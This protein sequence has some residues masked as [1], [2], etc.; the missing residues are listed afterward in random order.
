[1]ATF[2]LLGNFCFI[3]IDASS[4]GLNFV[5]E[6]QLF[7]GTVFILEIYNISRIG[8]AVR[9]WKNRSCSFWIEFGNLRELELGPYPI[10][11]YDNRFFSCSLGR[12][13]EKKLQLFSGT[14]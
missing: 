13:F 7:S 8:S 12:F 10:T 14:V 4:F 11:F 3:K 5:D 9:F 2:F 6:L 1:M